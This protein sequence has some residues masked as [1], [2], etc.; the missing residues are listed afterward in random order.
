MVNG[1]APAVSCAVSPT[2]SVVD[3]LPPLTVVSSCASGTRIRIRGLGGVG[4]QGRFF[5]AVEVLEVR[6]VSVLVGILSVWVLWM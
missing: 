2:V 1:A 4:T 6:L 3:A 5:Q